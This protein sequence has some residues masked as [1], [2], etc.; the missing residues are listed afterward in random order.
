[1]NGIKETVINNNIRLSEYTD[2]LRFGTDALLLAAFAT[3][4]KNKVCVDIGSGSGSV[5]LLLLSY[6][7]A[8]SVTGLEIQEKYAL[9]GAEN[10]KANGYADVY[11]SLCGDLKDHRKL[12]RSGCADFVVTNPPYMPPDCGRKNESEEKLIAR[13][14]VRCGIADVCRCASFVLRSGGDFYAVYRPERLTDLLCAMRESSIE[15]KRFIP[16]CPTASEKPSLI[17]VAGRRNAKPGLTWR[18]LAMYTDASHGTYTAD[19]AEA[20]ANGRIPDRKSE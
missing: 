1:M 15:P 17:L 8:A 18:Q 7:K 13:H 12:F 6:G 10:A 4:G 5:G 9:L 11:T 20:V 14:E 19:A 16:V 3:G 2:G